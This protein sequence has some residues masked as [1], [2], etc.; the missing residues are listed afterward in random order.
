MSSLKE[1]AFK[2]DVN[3]QSLFMMPVGVQCNAAIPIVTPLVSKCGSCNMIHLYSANTEWD[4][5]LPEWVLK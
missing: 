5:V 1:L 2:G 4:S 3:T